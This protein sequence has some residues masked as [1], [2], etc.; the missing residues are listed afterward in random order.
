V[1]LPVGV[2]ELPGDRVVEGMRRFR[3]GV[4]WDSVLHSWVILDSHDS[5][6]FKTIAGS[7]ERQLVG[8]GMQ[9]TTPGVPMVFAGDE[10]GLE[11]DWGEDARRTIPWDR[12]E[13]WDGRLLDAYRRLIALRRSSSALAKG[14]IRYAY[15]GSDAILYLRE[16]GE[17]RILCLARRREGEPLRMPLDAVGG[18]GIETVANEGEAEEPRVQD[19]WIVMPGEGPSFQ[20]MR[21]E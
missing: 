13:T 21:I 19:G 20:A 8:M 2:P 16:T 10:L 17:E 5:A 14:G 15:A 9:M 4:P 1:E 11:G 18:T 3:A 7:Q 12:P 6:R